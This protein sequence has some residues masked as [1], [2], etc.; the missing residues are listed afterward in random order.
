MAFLHTAHNDAVSHISDIVRSPWRKKIS[1]KR[2][3]FLYKKAPGRESRSSNAT[4]S[5]RL[6]LVKEE[7]EEEEEEEEEEGKV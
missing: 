2:F 5:R 1:H 4:F 7:Q 3:Y 6:R